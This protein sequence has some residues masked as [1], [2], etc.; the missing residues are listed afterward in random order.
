MLN[1]ATTLPTIYNI[2]LN[3]HNNNNSRVITING[4][5]LYEVVFFLI[6]LQNIT[7]AT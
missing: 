4:I 1:L 7:P 2:N 5:E 3:Y 6:K